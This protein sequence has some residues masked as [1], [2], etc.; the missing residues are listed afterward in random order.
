MCHGN[1]M[2]IDDVGGARLPGEGSDLVCFLDSE[3]HDVA[4]AQKS[5]QLRLPARTAYLGHHWRGGQRDETELESHSMVR[6]HRPI[7]SIGGDER[8]SVVDDRHAG[9]RRR[10]ATA[11]TCCAMRSRAAPS[12]GS[13]NRPCR[14]SHSATAARPSRTR[15]AR[16]AALVIHAE[17]L[18]PSSAA[19]ATSWAWTSGSTVIASF[20]DGFPLGTDQLYYYGRTLE[21]SDRQAVSDLQRARVGDCPTVV[22]TGRTLIST[23][24]RSAAHWSAMT[25]NDEAP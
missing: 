7:G 21:L 19:A 24:R 13:V 11:R 18:T 23:P 2:D 16:L 3:R 25:L 5:S 17:T 8:T 22:A 15:S 10:G 12:S 6:P 14:R 20:G 4:A 9:R 1:H